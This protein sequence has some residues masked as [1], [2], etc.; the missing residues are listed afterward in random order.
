MGRAFGSVF[1]NTLSGVLLPVSRNRQH[2]SETK[3]IR[4]QKNPVQQQQPDR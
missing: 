2:G 4:R 1:L 3:T